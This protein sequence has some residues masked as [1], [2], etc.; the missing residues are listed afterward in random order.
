MSSGYGSAAWFH[1]NRYSAQSACEHCG[2]VVR[3]E[4]WCITI[5]PVV[6]YAYQ[7]V[8][9]PSKL[10]LADALMLHALGVAWGNPACWGNCR[11]PLSYGWNC[12]HSVNVNSERL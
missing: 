3:H 2:G 6:Y 12:L 5:D 10:T 1:S 4:S 8:L 11:T 7:I 9:D